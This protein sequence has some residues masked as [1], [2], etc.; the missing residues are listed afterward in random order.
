M[1]DIFK[2]PRAGAARLIAYLVVFPGLA[3]ALNVWIFAT[4]GAQWARTLENP[5][6]SP[7]GPAIGAAWVALFALMAAS[8]WLVDRAGQLE[9][10]GPARTLI[11]AQYAVNMAWTWFYF[12][13]QDVANGFYLTAI[14][15]AVSIAAL[16]AIWRANFNAA[17]FWLPLNLWLAFALALSYA[18]WRLNA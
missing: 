5:A 17:L 13:L 16:F 4:G 9:A 18:T 6:W 11:L 12:G 14:A 15:L 10:R 7:P 1:P 2:K 8:L 3:V